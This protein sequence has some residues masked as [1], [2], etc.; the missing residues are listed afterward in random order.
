[1]E[2]KRVPSFY[3]SR[4][5]KFK[6]SILGLIRIHDMR[7]IQVEFNLKSLAIPLL[8]LLHEPKKYYVV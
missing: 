5:R 7:Q 2:D 1:M 3:S 4:C 6:G 8:P